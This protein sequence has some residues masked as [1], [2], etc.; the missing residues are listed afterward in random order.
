MGSIDEQ[1]LKTAKEV[2]IK[3][4]ECGRLSPSGFAETFQGIYKAV[5]ETV[6]THLKPPEKPPE[7]KPA[8]GSKQ[9]GGKR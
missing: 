2:V 6:K 1:V 3:F 7:A 9:T 5:D 4:I 8:A